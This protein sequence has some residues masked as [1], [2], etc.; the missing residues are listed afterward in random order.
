M[1]RSRNNI[2]A[3]GLSG[4]IAQLLFRQFYGKTVISHLPRHSGFFSPRQK[5]RQALFQAAS[6][7]ADR[8]KGDPQLQAFYRSRLRP[9]QTTRNLAISDYCKPPVIGVL[10]TSRYDGTAGTLLSIA[11]TDNGRVD[12]VMF[13]VENHGILLEE[14]DAT[15]QADGLQW[16]Y[17]TR[18]LHGRPGPITITIT[19]TDA[20]GRV[21]VQTKSI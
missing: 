4:K 20:A 21:S 2:A 16:A 19:A 10:D 9:G 17:T 14:G 8:V 11:V 13:R 7:Y 1:A 18:V 6:Q 3:E 15:L 12:A 5:E